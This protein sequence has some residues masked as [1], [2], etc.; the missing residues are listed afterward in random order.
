MVREQ[1]LDA[2][3]AGA[4]IGTLIGV[5]WVVPNLLSLFAAL[6]ALGVRP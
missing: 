3:L 1:T 2:I 4:S 6:D 5:F